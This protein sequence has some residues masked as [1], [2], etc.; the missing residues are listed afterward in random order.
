MENHGVSEEVMEEVFRQSK[1]FFSLGVDDKMTV[2]ADK[3]NRGYTPLQ[4]QV[5]DPD[6]QTKGDT[7]VRALKQQQQQQRLEKATLLHIALRMW[8]SFGRTVDKLFGNSLV[9]PCFRP[10]SS[11]MLGPPAI[12]SVCVFGRFS[13][14]SGKFLFCHGPCVLA[15]EGPRL[16]GFCCG[17]GCSSGVL[18]VLRFSDLVVDVSIS[19]CRFDLPCTSTPHSL[20]SPCL[21]RRRKGIT[22][23][24]S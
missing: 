19:P 5:L 22:S 24:E 17:G 13:F 7:K 9:V 4:E 16:G 23:S 21:P 8:S 20:A 18:R 1:A 3:N 2:K 12:F 6:N 15:L 10:S 11:V 14:L